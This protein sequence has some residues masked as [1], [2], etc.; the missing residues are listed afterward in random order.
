M[1]VM[2]RFEDLS[3]SE[4]LDEVELLH[5]SQ[6]RTEIL[7]LKAAVRHADLNNPSTLDPAQAGLPGRERAVRLGGEGT[8]R[9]VSSPPAE[10]GARLQLSSYAAGRLMADGLDLRHRFPRLWQRVEAMEVRVGHARYVARRT[11]D[12]TAQQAAFVDERVAES[13]DGRLTWTRFTDLVEAM[14]VASDP[15]AA[16]EREEV[17][18]RAQFAR[19]TRSTDHGMR[20]FYIRAPFP[21]IARIDATVAYL[22]DAL[23]ALGDTSTLD[24]RRVKA[25]LVMANPTEAV[26]LLEAYRGHR[27]R[28]AGSTGP[29]TDAATS[30]V[31]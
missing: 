9:C 2:E 1:R 27:S 16:A 7:I 19:P 4:L 20:G 3:G 5:E 30:A 10:L 17:A 15:V 29:T 31:D 8:P 12:L 11:R 24:E 13:A 28:A 26:Q 21:V 23:L 18:A 25:L 22:A 14:I 6:R